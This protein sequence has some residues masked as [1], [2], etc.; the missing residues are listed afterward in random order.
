[1]IALTAAL[2]LAVLAALNRR[3]AGSWLYPPAF[4]TAYWSVLLIALYASGD[5]FYP[6][7]LATV[8]LLFVGKLAFSLG[9]LVVLITLS[10]S[11]WSLLPDPDPRR[12]L[13]VRVFLD[14]GIL[15]LLA[16]LPFYW[17]LVQNASKKSGMID[18]WVGVRCQASEVTDG[19]EFGEFDY[20]MAFS[21]VLTLIALNEFDGKRQRCAPRH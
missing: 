11:S 8:V 17:A 1:M 12:K 10:R 16:A 15:L 2:L 13:A 19:K 18:F 3:I 6:I 21:N 14:C 9:G 4:F 7:S 5:M 20:I